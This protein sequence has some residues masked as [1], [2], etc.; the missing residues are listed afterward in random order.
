V[1]RTVKN[2]THRHINVQPS[3]LNNIVYFSFL[4]AFAVFFPCT[5]GKNEYSIILFTHPKRST[6]H[7]IISRR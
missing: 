3:T 2:K 1:Q 5:L 6:A 7:F 4:R